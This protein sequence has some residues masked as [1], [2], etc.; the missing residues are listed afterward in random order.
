M[1]IRKR[2]CEDSLG[3]PEANPDL[4]QGEKRRKMG[5]H[6]DDHEEKDVSPLGVNGDSSEDLVPG[7]VASHNDENPPGL[8]VDSG[9]SGSALTEVAPLRNL[10]EVDNP[11]KITVTNVDT[12]MGFG[13]YSDLSYREVTELHKEYVNWALNQTSPSGDLTRYVEWLYSREGRFIRQGNQIFP[14]GQHRGET[15]HKIATTDPFYHVRY[16]HM[17]P[18]PNRTLDRYIRYFRDFKAN[19]SL[20]NGHGF[21]NDDV[22]LGEETFEFGQHVGQTWR[23][24]AQTDPT[25]HIR[26]QRK[27]RM[28]PGVIVRYAKWFRENVAEAPTE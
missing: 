13:K 23:Q 16:K 3:D 19:A 4:A 6:P 7:L 10:E 21:V 25:Y 28:P 5:D 15:F 22:D 2:E 27:S 18:G 12:I 24:V 1:D 9:R 11:K 8:S 14:F 26:F 17:Q 20:P